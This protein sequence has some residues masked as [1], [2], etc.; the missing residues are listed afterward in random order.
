LEVL[1]QD[2]D[3]ELVAEGRV[4]VDYVGVRQAGQDLKLG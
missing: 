4:G 2:E 1:H 3:V